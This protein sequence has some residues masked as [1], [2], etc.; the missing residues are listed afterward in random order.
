MKVIR[1][2]LFYGGDGSINPNDDNS[3]HY[4]SD[5]AILPVHS[6]FSVTS[7]P[8]ST[9][10]GLQSSLGGPSVRA[11]IAFTGG[12]NGDN[13]LIIGGVMPNQMP[14]DEEPT[15]YTY[16]ID[17][18]RWNSFSLPRENRLNRQGA[19]C[20]IT[21]NGTA[22]V[23]LKAVVAFYICGLIGLEVDLG[24]QTISSSTASCHEPA[25]QYLSLRFCSP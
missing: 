14:I 7:P 21:K 13:M 10:S 17:L 16:D 23:S 19:G 18:G 22:Y 6:P 9:A 1:S 24:R 2:I 20:T 3:T 11:H 15:A 8:W 12:L 5:L 4:L 25:C